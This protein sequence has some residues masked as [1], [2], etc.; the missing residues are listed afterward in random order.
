MSEQN[1][2][3]P[4][5][6]QPK[7]AT[8]EHDV[9]IAKIAAETAR[10]ALKFE[11]KKFELAHGESSKKSKGWLWK[12]YVAVVTVAVFGFLFSSVNLR[13]QIESARIGVDRDRAAAE[14]IKANAEL[15]LARQRI[16]NQAAPVADVNVGIAAKS[17]I[18]IQLNAAKE[19]G[20]PRILL[21]TVLSGIRELG[22]AGIDSIKKKE[23]LA[24]KAAEEAVTA[25]IGG[26]KEI[27]VYAAERLLDKLLKPTVDERPSRPHG[28]AKANGTKVDT[29]CSAAPPMI[30]ALDGP[31]PIWMSCA[32]IAP[33]ACCVPPLPKCCQPQSDE[34]SQ[35]ESSRDPK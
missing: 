15:E 24:T 22:S 16:G 2:A 17:N 6:S 28:G 35:T 10:A 11:K 26:A 5:Q 20:K 31:P 9:T 29:R 4:E 8:N 7:G 18:E 25:G 3:T 23:A 19:A 1:A 33:P 14:V 13:N 32:P 12:I 30:K 21:D 27:S 34:H